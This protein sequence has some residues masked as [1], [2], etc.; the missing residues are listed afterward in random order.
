ML[1]QVRALRPGGDAAGGALDRIWTAMYRTSAVNGRRR[2]HVAP[3]VVPARP[4]GAVCNTSAARPAFIDGH[5]RL[6][7]ITRGS[8]MCVNGLFIGV[9]TLFKYCGY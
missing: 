8:C 9:N 2:R 6:Y 3:A 7:P 4:I 1:V 5:D